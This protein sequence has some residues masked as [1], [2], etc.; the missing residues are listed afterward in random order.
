MGELMRK[1]K[2]KQTDLH[3]SQPMGLM[4]FLLQKMGGMSRTSVKSLLSHRQV[5][6]NNRVE[7]QYNYALS[8]GDKVVVLTS[9]ANMELIHPKLRIVF[10]DNDLLVV[11]KKTGILTVP[12]NVGSRESTVLSVLKTYVR[13][14][15]P[16]NGVFVVHRLDRETSGLLVFAKSRELQEFMR[17]NWKLVTT[18]RAYTAL[19]EG[20]VEKENDTV[21]SWLTENPKTTR[22]YSS[23]TDNGGKKSIT[24]YEKLQNNADYS[25]IELR[26]ETGRTNQIRV[27][28][29]SIGHPVVGDRKYGNG[30]SP[31]MNRLAL[32]AHLL[33]FN[34]P[35]TRQKMSFELPVPKEFFKVFR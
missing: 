12:T 34:H 16:R 2:T 32:H 11:E 9:A 18:D 23:F 25:L 26:L 27:Q 13:K 4:E 19:V 24:H 15:N 8:V 20:V 29:A 6:V 1:Q 28:M 33:A 10:E 5:Q 35:V 31:V 7:T 14:A 22:V 3:V 21:V 30:V 17:D